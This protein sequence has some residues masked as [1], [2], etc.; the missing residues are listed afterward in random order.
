MR[1]LAKMRAGL[2]DPAVAD[3]LRRLEGEMSVKRQLEARWVIL[4]VFEHNYI[5]PAPGAYLTLPN[6]GPK[7]RD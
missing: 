7:L 5:C 4:I 3:E 1:L 2:A 6:R